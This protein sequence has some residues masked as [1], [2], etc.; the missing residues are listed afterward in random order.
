MTGRILVQHYLPYSLAVN[1]F[2]YI[3]VLIMYLGVTC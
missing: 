2:P 3:N 1:H